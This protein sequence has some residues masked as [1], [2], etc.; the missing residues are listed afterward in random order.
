MSAKQQLTLEEIEATPWAA[1][2]KADSPVS[3]VTA[4]RYAQIPHL[5]VGVEHSDEAGCS[6]WVIRVADDPAFWMDAKDT[7]AEAKQ[8]CREMGWKVVRS[9]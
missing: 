2:F 5:A 4:L 7:K 9:W 1:E 6:Q 3:Y 8:V